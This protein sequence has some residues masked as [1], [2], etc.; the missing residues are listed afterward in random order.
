MR[1]YFDNAASTKILNRF[2]EDILKVFDFYANP[3]SVHA[4]GKKARYEIEKVRE[5]ISSSLNISNSKDLIFTSGAT[6][7]NNMIIKGV[8]NFYGKGHI[9]TTGIEHPSVLNVCRYLETKGF[10][11]TYLKPNEDGIVTSDK[12]LN[13]IK[14]NTILVCVMAVN[15]ETGVKQPIEEIGNILKSKNI[16][17]HSDMV[18]YLLK[19]KIDVEKLNLSSFSASFHKFHGPK[20]LGLA[21]VKNT[22]KIEKFMHGGSHEKNKR[23]GTE[24]LQSIILGGIVYRYMNENLSENIKYMSKISDKFLRGLKEFEG[25]IRLNNKENRVLNIFNIELIDKDIQYILPILDMNGVSISGGSACQSGSLSPSY[26]LLEQGLSENQAKGS[27]RISL[28]IENTEEEIDR[29]FEILR[30]II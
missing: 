22:S 3:S 14:D 5:Y 9:I 7:S 13:A 27:I 19:E 28:S 11:L 26:V 30:K 4:E 29:F 20:G 16:H 25:K 23:A 21:Y 6:E 15:N 10:E 2:R 8:A 18:Q 12:V 1:I 17:F 24:N